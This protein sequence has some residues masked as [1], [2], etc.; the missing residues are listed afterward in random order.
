MS[1]ATAG[2]AA[3]IADYSFDSDG[4]SAPSAISGVTASDVT[5]GSGLDANSSVSSNPDTVYPDNLLRARAAGGPQDL[6]TAISN[7]QLWTFTIAIDSSTTIDLTSLDFEVARGGTSGRGFAI[8]SDLT[9]STVLA[10][11]DRSFNNETGSLAPID[12]RPNLTAKS[13][14]LSNPEFQGLTDTSVTFTFYHF[15][16][17]GGRDIEFNDVQV[18][19]EL[20]A[21]PEPATGPLLVAALL[22]GRSRRRAR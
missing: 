2:H 12:G 16:G 19:A 15:A 3:L 11:F 4:S 13:V 9:G 8:L 1:V 10:D 14:A 6:A 17:S 18:N 7:D 20:S 22:L 5:L 21:V